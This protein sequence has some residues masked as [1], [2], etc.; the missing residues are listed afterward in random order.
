MASLFMIA[1]SLLTYCG[2][3][4]A[5]QSQDRP[6]QKNIHCSQWLASKTRNKYI[7]YEFQ[8]R[9]QHVEVALGW[10][11]T[12]EDEVGILLMKCPY[13]QVRGHNITSEGYFI[14]PS[15]TSKLNNYMCG[16]MKR[17]GQV[18]MDCIDGFGPSYTSLGYECS[19]CTGCW[20]GV[21]LYLLVELVPNTIFYLIILTFQIRLTSAPMIGFIWYSQ[22]VLLEI[23][24]S[25]AK[26]ISRILYQSRNASKG[27]KVIL[28]LYGMWNLDFIRYLVPPFCISLKLKTIHIAFLDYTSAIYPLFLICLTWICIKLYGQNFRPLVWVWRLLHRCNV[29]SSRNRDAK[30]D[31]INVFTSFFF[32]SY[33]KLV[34]QSV[35]LLSC[36]HIINIDNASHYSYVTRVDPSVNCYSKEYYFFATPAIVIIIVCVTLPTLLFLLYPTRVFQTCFSKCNAY[37]QIAVSIFME[38]FHSCYRDGLEGG[39][40]MRRFCGFYF[41]LQ[42]LTCLYYPLNLKKLSVAYRTYQII[43]LASASILIAFTRPYKKSYMNVLESLLLALMALLYHFLSKDHKSDGHVKLFVTTLIPA[44]VFITFSVLKMINKICKLVGIKLDKCHTVKCV[45]SMKK[46]LVELYTVSS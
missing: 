32:L 2:T 6:Q 4:T 15:N 45:V 9:N 43:L 24:Y 5:V 13:F 12:Y 37:L 16:P 27:L 36:H 10:C 33:S 18:C 23:T 34:Y 29:I 40:D 39:R 42:I 28:A 1:V 46:K 22:T 25:G 31:I 11:A 41:Y 26:P 20:Y 7:G 17:K 30:N 44:M 35:K 38:K 19:N 14:L 21:P 8:C 3:C